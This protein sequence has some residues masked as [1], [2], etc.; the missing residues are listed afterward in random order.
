MLI[1][2]YNES[3]E[4]YAV[5]A[6]RIDEARAGALLRDFFAGKRPGTVTRKDVERFKAHWTARGGAD[7]GPLQ[8]ATVNQTT[9]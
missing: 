2:E 4:G 5:V 3:P 9:V 8:D 7:G 6:S 1:A